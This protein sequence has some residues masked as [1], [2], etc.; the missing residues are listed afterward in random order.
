M[1]PLAITVVEPPQ[2][3]AVPVLELDELWSD[4]GRK[5]QPIW[6]WI[7]FTR[8]SRQVVAYALGDRTATTARQLWER[9][10]ARYRRALAYTDGWEPDAA[11]I[12]AHHHR[13]C[14]KRDGQTAHV[15]RWN[16]TVRQRLARYTRKTLAFSKSTR[17]HEACLALFIYRYNLDQIIL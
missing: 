7:A 11:V 5:S 14:P 12:P 9:L 16:N 8:H 3:V 17:M 10:P 15:E 13:A 6:L 4:V 2:N 1:P